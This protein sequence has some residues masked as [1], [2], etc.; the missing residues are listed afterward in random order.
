MEVRRL[1][2]GLQERFG[3]RVAIKRSPMG[4]GRLTFSF[5]SDADLNHLLSLLGGDEF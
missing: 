4:R 1:E 3:T 2:R 5:Y